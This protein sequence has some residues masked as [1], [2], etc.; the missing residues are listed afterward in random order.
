MSSATKFDKVFYIDQNADVALAINN[1]V[2]EDAFLHFEIFG[3]TEF[4]APNTHFSFQ[5]Y[6]SNN[7]DVAEAVSNG[8]FKSAFHHYQ[9]FGETEN[10]VPSLGFTGFN[11]VSYL[12]ENIDVENAVS[13]GVFKSALE[14]YIEFGRFEN[15][16]GSDVAK[17]FTLSPDIDNI[18][19]SVDN[20]HFITN[21]ASLTSS[22]KLD[23]G[24][25]NDTLL[26]TMEDATFEN[27]ALPFSNNLNRTE[28]VIIDLTNILPT[29]DATNI[30]DFSMYHEV[31]NLTLKGGATIDDATINFQLNASQAFYIDNVVDG[32]KTTS[33]I[34]DGGI[35]INTGE[36]T[37]A[38]DLHLINAGPKNSHISGSGSFKS[39]E[40]E[41]LVI[42][43][44]TSESMTVDIN[45]TGENTIILSDEDGLLSKLNIEGTGSTHLLSIPNSIMEI[46]GKATEANL[47]FDLPNNN[48]LVKTGAGND[49]VFARIGSNIIHTSDGDDVVTAQDGEHQI[50]TGDGDDTVTVSQGFHTVSTRSGNDE[51]TVFGG[52]N[53]VTSG[54]GNDTVSL[55]GGTNI[56]SGGAGND[57][58]IVSGE[59]ADLDLRQLDGG[60]GQDQLKIMSNGNIQVP[61]ATN[62]ETVSIEDNIHQSL[63]FSFSSSI[64][65]IELLSGTTTDGA[66]IITTLG[67]GQALTL[68]SITDGD[69]TAASLADGGIR[70][71]QADSITDLDLTLNDIGPNSAV[72]NQNVFLDLA[73]TGVHTANITST[74]ES[75]I[76]LENSG[77]ALSTLNLT[78]SG[79]LGIMSTLADTITIVNGVS[80][81]ANLT[82]ST[83]GSDSNIT[84]GSGSDTITLTGG[85]NN[86]SSGDGDDTINLSTGNDT[87]NT[88]TGDDNV[89]ASAGANN[90][91]TGD[92]DDQVTINGGAN[93]VNTGANDDQVTINGGANTVNTGANDDQVNISAGTNSVDMESG[94]DQITINGGTNT[95][96]SGT[97]DDTLLLT[98]GVNH[99]ESGDGDDTITASGGASNV[100]I[101][102]LDG[103]AGIDR[104]NIISTGNVTLPSATNIENFFIS[105]TVHQSLDFSFSTSLNG[106]E[107]DSGTTIDNSIITLTLGAGQALTLDSITDGDTAAASLSDGGISIAQAASLTS[108]DLT[109]DDVG[110]STSTAN[111]NVF[112]DIA[113]TGVT[114]AKVTSGNDSFV[115]ISN[116]GGNLTGI[117]L[118][119]TGTIALGTLPTSITNIN[120]TAAT[121][122]LTLTIGSTGVNTFRGGIGDDAVTLTGGTNDVQTGDGDDIITT[123]TNL[124]LGDRIDGGNGTDTFEVIHTGLATIPTTAN[125]VSIERFAIQD[126]VHQS[127]DFS[128]LTSITGIEL[129]SGTTVDNATINTVLGSGQSLT[130]DS[131]TDGDTSA[132][133]LSDGGIKISQPN[134]TTSL[135]L[136]LDDIGPAAASTNENVVIDVAGANVSDLNI[137]SAN[138]SFVVLENSGASISTIN[139]AGSGTLSLIGALPNSITTINAGTSSTSFTVSTGTA[140]ATITGSSANDVI[141]LGGGTNNVDS[142]NGNDAITLST[143]ND[144]V[145][146]GSGSDTVTASSGTNNITT[147]ASGDQITLSGGTN[148]VNSGASNDQLTISGG[149]NNIDT[150]SGNDQITISGGNNTL[151]TGNNNDTIS[152]SN[153]VNNINAGSGND[154]IT[155]TGGT[156]TLVTGNNNDTINVSGGNNDIDTD[157]GTD[158]VVLTGG[159]NDVNTGSNDDTVTLS[160]GTETVD[161]GSGNDTVEAGANLSTSDTVNGGDG[162]GDTIEITSALTDALTA[163]LSNFEIL[164][165]KGGG[166]ITHDITGLTGLTSLKASGALTGDIVITDLAKAAELDISAAIGNNLTINQINSAGGS[167]T[168][169]IDLRGGSYT[170][171]G[172]VIA[173]NIETV[174]IQT[175]QNGN[176]TLSGGTFADATNIAIA[177]SRANLTITDLT[178]LNIDTLDFSS[179]NRTVNVTTGTDVFAQAFTFTGGNRNDTLNLDGATLIAGTTYELGND[180]DTLTMNS[181][182]VANVVRTAATNSN[183]A[184]AVRDDATSTDTASFVS[185]SDTFDYNGTIGHAGVS[186]IVISSGASLQAAVAADNDA[187]VYIISDPDG[188]ADLEAALNS[189][190]DGVSDS[191]ALA[192]KTEALDT[193]LL[194]YSGLDAN[195]DSTDF[196]L[197]VIDSETNEEGTTANNGGTAVFRFNNSDTS[198][199]DTISS[200]ELA[201]IGV[202]QDAA[203][204]A[205]DFI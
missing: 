135:D 141:V 179:S 77:S 133:S 80:S 67:I 146:T 90:I 28:N 199:T 194:S 6:F 152:A 106:I 41:A 107:L 76:V 75:F 51:I 40:K 115:V 88:G 101:R 49:H 104:L 58:I 182:A 20:D 5:Y 123:T 65:N 151:T 153:G 42:N 149:T 86:V 87:V 167:D 148:T 125:L 11:P 100:D 53:T 161:M 147:G 98:A 95:V 25:G 79:T 122:N 112:I 32:D 119:G 33:S 23:G 52:T 74:N 175:N 159:T 181:D 205:A 131:I 10:R 190:A 44:R 92:N 60:P 14:H 84:T 172:E 126:T 4:R 198:D 108:L 154:Q 197:I 50:I 36:N 85:S 71:S 70:I 139:I 22:D 142:G 64:N 27:L 93:T 30:I 120:G 192:L 156:N 171:G 17:T 183:N 170:T 184:F 35:K 124:A 24:G 62:F 26:I 13:E 137:I 66:T 201:L 46:N 157:A 7:P 121:A 19:G 145:N 193:G 164:E 189:F 111:E 109:L 165:I 48:A 140:G 21:L 166:G 188:D 82:F 204:A 2:I 8:V 73:G 37:V 187:T 169:T 202:F 176:K 43:L 83:G 16:P 160:S 39:L 134:S 178:A 129:D 105:D 127:L 110:P 91:T 9:V 144:T 143:G 185:G 186:S 128:A 180:L 81:S 31:E 195:F 1:G 174:T 29:S 45:V 155:L 15:R 114:T 158:E 118:L 34:N 12:V 94:N 68:D 97:G 116:T 102:T 162:T 168:L 69:T 89:T 132:A 103:G 196:V 136:T 55:S 56:V 117:E 177:A 3:A 191:R 138:D 203:L 54:D 47:T 38:F 78:G 113:G 72:T 63:D 173:P 59:V 61:T 18:V 57:L 150:E 96:S 130:L 163:R 99:I 200:S